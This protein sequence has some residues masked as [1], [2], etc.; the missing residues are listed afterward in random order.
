M[1]LEKLLINEASWINTEEAT[2]VLSAEWFTELLSCM[3]SCIK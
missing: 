1:V 3:K 2:L